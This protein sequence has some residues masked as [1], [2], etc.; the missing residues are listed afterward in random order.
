MI[1]Y[2]QPLVNLPHYI[3]LLLVEEICSR[4]DIIS[5]CNSTMG[6]GLFHF[7]GSTYKGTCPFCRQK[8]VFALNKMLGIYT[9]PSC[10]KV[11][12]F[13]N[14]LSWS[15]SCDLNN[16]L[17]FLSRHLEKAEYG[18]IATAGGKE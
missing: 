3:R 9:C 12:D 8:K 6:L 10:K 13:F 4:M 2:D 15:K 7:K 17:A 11:S 1:D 16:A 14:L 5:Y 18:F